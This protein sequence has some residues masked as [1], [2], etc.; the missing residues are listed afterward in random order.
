[1]CWLL[2]ADALFCATLA[3]VRPF[4]M[5]LFAAAPLGRAKPSLL[6][7]GRGTPCAVVPSLLLTDELSRGLFIP[8]AE[9]GR[10]T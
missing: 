1:M 5:P 3:A 6:D 9:G 7:G 10:G 2:T 8:P 4:V